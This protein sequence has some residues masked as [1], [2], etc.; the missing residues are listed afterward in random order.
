MDPS[1]FASA[2]ASLLALDIQI[3]S[4]LYGDWD[5]GSRPL[6]DRLTYELTQIRTVLQALEITSLSFAEPIFDVSRLRSCLEDLKEHLLWLGPK[7]SEPG[8]QR[9]E[10]QWRTMNMLERSGFSNLSL[11]KC[12]SANEL[13]YLRSSLSKL[14]DCIAKSPFRSP[15]AA[16]E[17]QAR[18][19]GSCLW[20]DCMDYTRSHETAR[21]TRT[22]GTGRWLL[23]DKTYHK[24]FAV[25]RSSNVLYCTGR[26]GSG[27]TV[28]T[29]LVV[30][31]IRDLQQHEPSSNIGLAYF[32]FSY[33][34]PSPMRGV[35]LALLEQLFL[36]SLTAPDEVLQLEDR[37]SKGEQ[38]PF[39]EILS[40][41]SSVS[42]R[43]QKC[44]IVLDALD[45]CADDYQA[46]LVHLLSSIRDSRS[47]LFVTSRPFQS[48]AMFETYPRISVAP[49]AEDVELY[50]TSQLERS[51]LRDHPELLQQVVGAIIESSAQHGMFLL[52]MLQVREVLDKHTVKGTTEW[53][54]YFQSHGASEGNL[55]NAYQKELA[56]ISSLSPDLTNLAAWTLTWLYFAQ[57]PLNARELLDLLRTTEHGAVLKLSDSEAIGLI[58][59]SCMGLVR[60]STTITFTHFS[61]KEFFDYNKDH[62][63]LHPEYMVAERCLVYISLCKLFALSNS[64]EV[65]KVVSTHPFLLYA[66]NHWGRHVFN[67][68]PDHGAFF[69]RK[70]ILVLEEP[71]TVAILGQISLLPRLD[72]KTLKGPFVEFSALHMIAH[73]GLTW[74]LDYPWDRFISGLLAHLTPQGPGFNYL[75]DS[76][77]RT[78]LH[79]AAGQGHTLCLQKLLSMQDLVSKSLRADDEGRT[80]WHYAAMSGNAQVI[81][82]LSARYPLSLD[83]ETHDVQGLSPLQYGV[84]Q[85]DGKAFESLMDAYPAEE[86]SKT[87]MDEALTAALQHGRIDIVRMLLSRIT[88][89]YEHLT[90][91][92]NSNFA[93]AVRLLLDYVD[94]LDNPATA[95]RTALLE[96][97]RTGNNT[98]LSFLIRSGAGVGE[99]DSNGL[100]ALAHAVEVG[101]VEAVGALLKA[102]ANPA[103]PYSDGTSLIMHAASRNM[104]DIL[105]LLIESGSGDGD[106]KEAAFLAAKEGH[107]DVVQLL[108]A[109][110]VLPNER[111]RDGQTLSEVAREAGFENIVALLQD[112][113]AEPLPQVVYSTNK[114]PPQDHKASTSREA[115]ST[116]YRV[117]SSSTSRGLESPTPKK[118]ESKECGEGHHTRLAKDEDVVEEPRQEAKEGHTAEP[119]SRHTAPISR[120]DAETRGK[121]RRKVPSPSSER[122]S[123]HDVPT[124]LRSTPQSKGPTPF[125]LLSTPIEPEYLALGM[126]VA[127]PRSPLQFYIPKQIQS[128][129]PLTS[130]AQYKTVQ[131]DWNVARFSSKTSNATLASMLEVSLAASR[132]SRGSRMDIHSPRLLRRQ[133]RNHDHVVKT[134][135][136]GNEEQLLDM[137]KNW[138]EVFVVVGLLIATDME[139]VD[140]QEEKAA[141][142]D[143]ISVGVGIDIIGL[144]A[145]IGAESSR[146]RSLSARY[147][148]DRV[149]AVQYRSLKLEN[150]LF[151]NLLTRAKETPLTLGA[152]FQGDTN[153]RVL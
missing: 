2:A 42:K 46:D 122:T 52:V 131:Y 123:Q 108:L 132:A 92:I 88:P 57:R 11:S 51:P 146:R 32:Y 14:K 3:L 121:A 28:L 107:Q 143:G 72:M 82:A 74:L 93:L 138:K 69:G 36:Q 76:W 105:Q 153:E 75:K 81:Q 112:T 20:N 84:I 50:A 22:E 124:T 8:L 63:L 104:I 58:V 64:E 54:E 7:V 9:L 12:G 31:E 80:P 13:V 66:A 129:E 130:E 97:A 110:G 29:S 109:S 68:G 23:S 41:L 114:V 99:T 47:R 86:A 21:E 151:R 100:T 103:T 25:D 95:Q 83:H 70:C 117:P 18:T 67:V 38:I 134:I 65:E 137:L 24:W 135:C 149:V 27:K 89:R 30:D 4:S 101:N 102:G 78:P 98:I 127:D 53:L 126:I 1:S 150:R 145:Q 136:Q 90:V 73:F 142:G 55:L 141:A 125:V 19:L 120:E 17:R 60:N 116:S 40:I 59:K 49:S 91:A 71:Q 118:E 115:P 15:E 35:T 96:A 6:V 45:E 43:F 56:Q 113:G 10:W 39:R 139:V 111:S 34:V 85:G 48:Y 148:G 61:V 37:A 5:E 152:Y 77:G 128:L 26:P 147:S 140:E 16:V 87:Y 62:P 44:Y 94:D 33:K 79:I 133:L 106:L 144:A 119:S